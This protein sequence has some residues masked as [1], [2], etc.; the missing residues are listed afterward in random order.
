MQTIRLHDRVCILI[1]GPSQPELVQGWLEFMHKK[2][3]KQDQDEAH[4][5][6]QSSH[7]N[8]ETK[9]SIILV[10]TWNVRRFNRY[11]KECVWS[12]LRKRNNSS[13]YCV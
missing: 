6:P 7:R 13:R 1:K 5:L 4:K 10:L 12:K 11:Y 9:L 8:H 3:G 2:Q